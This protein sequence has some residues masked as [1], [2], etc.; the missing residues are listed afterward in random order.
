MDTDNIGRARKTILIVEDDDEIRDFLSSLLT[1][2][3]YNVIALSDAEQAMT[4]FLLQTREIHLIISDIQLPG[5]SGLEFRREIQA[6]EPEIPFIVSSG[7]SEYSKD[8][9]PDSCVYIS[10][11]YRAFHLV[12]T[13]KRLLDGC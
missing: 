6:L 10:K 5:R 8:S 4:A 12:E 1:R 7:S 2:N 9:V 13:V 3:Q 11:P